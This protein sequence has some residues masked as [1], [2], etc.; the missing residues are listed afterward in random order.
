MNQ[1]AEKLGLSLDTLT[2]LIMKTQDKE[3]QI[4]NIDNKI[5]EKSFEMSQMNVDQIQE[6]IHANEDKI[7]AKR[8]E[9]EHIESKSERLAKK[10]AGIR[11]A[12][13]QIAEKQNSIVDERN[14]RVGEKEIIRNQIRELERGLDEHQKTQIETFKVL[15]KSKLDFLN[16]IQ[17]EEL[18]GIPMPPGLQ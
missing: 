4:L 13:Q 8:M 17:E 3:Q 10:L 1:V 12:E 5:R 6:Q 2:K 18:K 9:I 15:Q 11:E 7:R 16:L 14:L